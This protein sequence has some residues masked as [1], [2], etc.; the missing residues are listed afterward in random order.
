MIITLNNNRK[1]TAWYCVNSH[2]SLS[3]FFLKGKHLIEITEADGVN[4][5]YTRQRKRERGRGSDVREWLTGVSLIGVWGRPLR[6]L[7]LPQERHTWCYLQ[8]FGKSWTSGNTH[9]AEPGP[10]LHPVDIWREW[11]MLADTTRPK[12]QTYVPENGKNNT[13]RFKHKVWSSEWILF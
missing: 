11:Y 13:I 3:C 4:K 10:G 8:G 9:R 7:I 1:W 5:K 2:Q 12:K 6:K